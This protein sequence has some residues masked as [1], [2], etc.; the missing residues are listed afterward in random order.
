MSLH[1]SG[2]QGSDEC[3]REQTTASSDQLSKRTLTGQNCTE[4]S[5]RQGK[6]E[7]ADG[8]SHETDALQGPLRVESSFRVTGLGI[9]TRTGTWALRG[10]TVGAHPL[11][12]PAWG[13]MWGVVG[14]GALE[15]ADSASHRPPVSGQT[16]LSAT[17][18]RAERTQLNVVVRS[19]PEWRR[20]RTRRGRFPPKSRDRREGRRGLPGSG[21]RD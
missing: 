21:C 14:R 10:G 20:V 7:V 18:E 11:I 9:A 4:E 8:C 13:A 5:G 15:R 19:S 3:R 16:P 2:D 12:A 1:E 17:V 6:Q